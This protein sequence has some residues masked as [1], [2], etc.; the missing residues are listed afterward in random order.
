MSS[1]DLVDLEAAA[2]V[3]LVDLDLP[4]EPATWEVC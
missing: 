2:N 4:V 1:D 3:G